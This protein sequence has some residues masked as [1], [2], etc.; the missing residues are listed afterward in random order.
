M[1]IVKGVK[2]VSGMSKAFWM[3]VGVNFVATGI[4]TLVTGEFQSDQSTIGI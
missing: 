4:L 3:L 1:E 2:T